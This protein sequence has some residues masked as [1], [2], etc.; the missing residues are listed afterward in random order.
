MTICVYRYDGDRVYEG[1]SLRSGDRVARVLLFSGPAEAEGSLR[2]DLLAHAQERGL[3]L[4]E[5]FRVTRDRRRCTVAAVVCDADGLPMA[6]P[7]GDH[8][9]CT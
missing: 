2:A 1:L 3:R 4:A 8:W 5:G 9:R 7:S 6:L